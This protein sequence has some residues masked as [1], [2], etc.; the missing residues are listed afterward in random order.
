MPFQKVPILASLGSFI[1]DD[2]VFKDNSKV[3]DIPGGAGLFAIYGMRI[4]QPYENSKRI[5]Y[6]LHKGF[7]H[8]KDIDDVIDRL[9]ISLISKVHPNKYTPRGLNTFGQNDHRDFEYIHP[10]IRVTTSDFPDEWIDSI[11]ILHIIS[12]PTRAA[13]TIIEWRD[14]EKNLEAKTATQFLWEPLPWACLPENEDII[15]EAAKLVKILSPNHEELAA[16]FGYSFPELLLSHNNDFKATVEYCGKRFMKRM[17]GNDQLVL[18][19]RCSKYGAMIMQQAQ[20]EASTEQKVQWVSAYYTNDQ[21]KVTDVTGAG[22]SFCGGYCYGWIATK[23]DPVESTFY[24]AVS[25][26][27]TVEQIGLPKLSNVASEETWNDGPRPSER[28]TILKQKHI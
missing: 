28:L 4:W 14:R 19:V 18:L 26:S 22:N 7:D 5:G 8:P 13:E 10:I 11:E 21:S 1:I 17:R 23:G 16:I 24:G 12:A 20:H 27:Y 25:A 6:I 2:I 3:N 9:N 15:Y